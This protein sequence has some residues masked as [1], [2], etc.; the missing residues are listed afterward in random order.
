MWEG[1]IVRF[2]PATG[3]FTAFRGRT[4]AAPAQSFFSVHVDG[5]GTVWAGSFRDGLFRYDPASRQFRPIPFTDAGETV[6]LLRHIGETRAGEFLICSEGNGLVILDPR[7]MRRTRYR[8]R[9]APPAD[10][11]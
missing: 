8:R 7:T 6:N 9:R 1:G 11:C 5:A 3:Q 2:D 10:P 4:S